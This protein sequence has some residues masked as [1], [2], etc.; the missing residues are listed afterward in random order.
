MRGIGNRAAPG[1]TLLCGLPLAYITLNMCTPQLNMHL[2]SEALCCSN[3]IYVYSAD[4]RIQTQVARPRLNSLTCLAVL[5]RHMHL[6]N[7]F[8]TLSSHA[9][10]LASGCVNSQPPLSTPACPNQHAI[11]IWSAR[12]LR[13]TLKPYLYLEHNPA[14]LFTRTRR[15]TRSTCP[16][17]RL[18]V[19][20]NMH[21]CLIT[22]LSLTHMLLVRLVRPTHLRAH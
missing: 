8:A 2:L 10:Q 19:Q 5:Q 1:R 18:T 3:A 11:T 17:V 9:L 15:S 12:P 7:S 20:F 4:S 6:L 14:H 21:T 13:S 16:L 22:L